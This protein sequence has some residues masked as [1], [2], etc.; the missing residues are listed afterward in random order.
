MW[1]I[2]QFHAGITENI[3]A[4]LNAVPSLLWLRSAARDDMPL[5]ID[6]VMKTGKILTGQIDSGT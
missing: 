5:N 6:P 3:M 1:Y 4:G 2:T